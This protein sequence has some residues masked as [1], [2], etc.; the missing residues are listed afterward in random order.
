ML[1][2]EPKANC[3]WLKKQDLEGKTKKY[4]E[5]LGAFSYFHPTPPHDC[6]LSWVTQWT[7]SQKVFS[8]ISK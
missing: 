2:V 7:S 4:Q 1:G 6:L 5:M 3:L 8:K